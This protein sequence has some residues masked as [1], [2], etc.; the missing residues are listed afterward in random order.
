MWDGL[1]WRRDATYCSPKTGIT[2]QST[3][4][5]A[6]WVLSCNL[7]D[8]DVVV[9]GGVLPK[10]ET[11]S[12][13]RVPY[14]AAAKAPREGKGGTGP[15]RPASTYRHVGPFDTDSH[16]SGMPSRVPWQACL[17]IVFGGVKQ[18]LQDRC[19][20][21]STGSVR[22]TA[23]GPPHLRVKE[24]KAQTRMVRGECRGRRVKRN[25]MWCACVYSVCV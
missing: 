25:N 12:R 21:P 13:R 19:E 20:T 16:M 4:V 23:Q 5:T 3:R 22:Q 8:V 17:F 1:Y 2:F 6:C 24:R 14:F 9:A 15:L 18:P 11:F 7:V 10:R